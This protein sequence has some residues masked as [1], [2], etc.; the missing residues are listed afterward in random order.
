MI[1]E[2]TRKFLATNIK[3][4]MSDMLEWMEARNA[5]LRA[6]SEFQGT[7]AEARM[8]ATLRGKER[9]ISELARALGVSRQAVHTTVHR[10]VNAGVV[11]L[12]SSPGNQ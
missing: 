7:P 5:D 9:S 8:F 10:L 12:V 4:L 1:D 3:G 6:G 2:Q 11:E